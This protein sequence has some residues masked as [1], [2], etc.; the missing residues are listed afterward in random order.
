MA[1]LDDILIYSRTEKEHL[2]MLDKALKHLLKAGLKV[3]LGKCSFFK[4]QI[5]YLGHLVSR[6]SNLPL[7]D[8]ITYTLT[9]HKPP[10]NIKEVRDLLGLTGYYHKC[11]CNYADIANPLNCWTCKAQLFIW[12][13]ECPS[14]LANTPIVQL[15][16]P[17]KP[18]LLFTD[19]I[20]FCYSGVLTQASTADSNEAL[21]KILTSEAL[22]KC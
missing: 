12:T 21:M 7:A 16:D 4:E 15:P 2:E 3:K 17:I 18:Y 22:P 14:R 5:H 10:T 13:L 6:M 20:K 9:K 19:A 8:K 1:Y 11:I